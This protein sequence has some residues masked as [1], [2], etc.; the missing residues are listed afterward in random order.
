MNRHL[1]KIISI[2]ILGMAL[3]ACSDFLDTNLDTYTTPERVQTRYSTLWSFANAFYAPMQSGFSIL[4][5]NLFAAASDEAIQT[6][7]ESDASFFNNGTINANINPLESLYKKYYEGIRAALFFLDY[8]K[9]GETFLTLNRDTS[10]VTSAENHISYEKQVRSLNW[11]RAE[12]HVAMAYYYS[13]L[14]KMYG[15]VPIVRGVYGNDGVVGNLTRADYDEVVDYIVELIDSQIDNLQ[16]DWSTHPDNVAANAGRFDKAAAMAI[17][18]RTLLYAASPRNNPDGDVNKWKRAAS[19][20]KD[21]IEFRNYTMPKNRS[22]GTF[23]AGA[24]GINDKEAIFSIRQAASNG[25]EAA[26]YPIGTPGGLSGITPTEN[27]VAD[28]EYIGLEDII[29]PYA[30]RDPRLAA[31]IVYNGSRWNGRTIDEA[32]KGTDDMAMKNSSRTGYYL[33]KFLTDNLNL[34]QNATAQH[35]WVVYRYAEVLLNYA[36][37]MNEAYGP[38]VVPEGYPKSAREALMEVRNSASTSLPA[39]TVTDKD[40]F[41]KVLKHERKIE[42]AFEDH[43]YWDLIRWLDAKSELSKPIKG[44]KVSKTSTGVFKYQT[45]VISNRTFNE[46]NYYMP[47]PQSE[48]LNS[49]GALIQNE[50]Y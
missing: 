22:Y 7:A 4:D 18:A 27:L 19:A 49:N 14:I 32:P 45:K 33:R 3:T 6:S 23:F 11:Y 47:F 15:G 20:A 17:K 31:T 21:L 1:T 16:E 30:N 24:N 29:N 46:R 12:A 38:D 50:G 35:V 8:A 2:S 43:R 41:R 34:Q 40:S 13:E 28:Y 48:I 42:L 37:A 39:V 36:E 26:N 25:P 44:V 5:D 9:D 10:S